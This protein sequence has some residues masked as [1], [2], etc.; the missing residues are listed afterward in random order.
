MSS[1]CWTRTSTSRLQRSV[2]CQLPQGGPSA[3]ARRL[4]RRA[5]IMFVR[6]RAKAVQHASPESFDLLVEH[7]GLQDG[8]D[9]AAVIAV[10]D[11]LPHRRRAMPLQGWFVESMQSD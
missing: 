11:V 5:R 6:G 7:A 8:D 1:A 2:G 10:A 9:E 3:Q 4:A